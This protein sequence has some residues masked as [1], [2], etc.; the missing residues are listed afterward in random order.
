MEVGEMVGGCE[1]DL[2]L[3]FPGGMGKNKGPDLVQ[4]PAYQPCGRSGRVPRSHS[5]EL[6]PK[7]YPP[8]GRWEDRVWTVEWSRVKRLGA[9]PWQEFHF[10]VIVRRR[11]SSHGAGVVG[12]FGHC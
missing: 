6:R 1:M 5:A 9:V 4:P 3:F 10:I 12:G 8:V 7:P 2:S 11:A